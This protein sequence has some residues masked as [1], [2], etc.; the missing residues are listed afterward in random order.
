M[1]SDGKKYQWNRSF[2]HPSKKS[3]HDVKCQEAVQTV[4][5][6]RTRKSLS[7]TNTEVSKPSNT[8]TSNEQ[9]PL[10]I[11]PRIPRIP[12]KIVTGFTPRD[13]RVNSHEA[14]TESSSNSVKTTMRSGRVVRTPKCFE[15]E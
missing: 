6:P 13:T 9:Q 8:T 5:V 15:P 3:L 11:I 4:S 14:C 7:T 2:V 1:E 12:V 10:P